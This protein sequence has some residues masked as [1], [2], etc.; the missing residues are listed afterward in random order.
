MDPALPGMPERMLRPPTA[1]PRPH[2]TP[3]HGLALPSGALSPLGPKG[4]AKPEGAPTPRIDP[5]RRRSVPRTRVDLPGRRS[6]T[7]PYSEITSMLNRK[8]R[9]LAAAGALALGGVAGLTLLANQTIAD[10]AAA[11]LSDLRVAT[12]DAQ[13]A[14]ESHPAFADLMRQA[15]AAEQ[16]MMAAQQSGDQQAMMGI[17]QQFQMRQQQVITQFQQDVQNLLPAIA[18]AEGVHIVA[19]DIAYTAPGIETM[20]IT[21]ELAEGFENSTPARS[22]EPPATMEMQPMPMPAP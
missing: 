20:D 11:P 19:L 15:Q 9:N 1:S 14:F 17:Q 3:A 21:G 4:I 13:E 6:H 5:I 18:E 7:N 10:E 16:E 12:Y 2:R 8:N 22:E